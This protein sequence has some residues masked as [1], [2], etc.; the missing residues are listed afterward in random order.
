L[1]STGGAI[2]TGGVLGSGGL[3]DACALVTHNNGRGQTWQDC[4][5]LGTINDAQAVKAC[6][7]SS[8]TGCAASSSCGPCY[9]DSFLSAYV[10]WGHGTLGG[11][12][13]SGRVF[14][15]STACTPS[16]VGSTWN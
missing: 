1:G 8:A 5:P 3:V 9:Y 13:V 7:A 11:V 6:Q 16:V 14:S 2:S 4:V 12:D 15:A 10:C